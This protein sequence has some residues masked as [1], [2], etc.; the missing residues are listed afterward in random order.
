MT[1]DLRFGDCLNLLPELGPV[2]AVLTDLPYGT[3]QCAW[4]SVIPL[5]LMW[6]SVARVLK[7]SG[8]FVTTASQPFTS[9]LIMSNLD[10]YRYSWVWEKNTGTRF[11]D[12][13]ERPLLFHED[14]C[15]FY[16]EQGTYNPQ[17]Q[18]GPATHSRK[19]Q[20]RTT[21]IY[22]AQRFV[23]SDESGMKYPRTV[24]HFDRPAPS[25]KTAHP[26]EKPLD[27]Y[28]YLVLTYTNP[29]DT[30][31]DLAM[32]SGTTGEACVRLGRNFVGIERDLT[33]FE[34]AEKRI[35]EAEAQ[36]ALF[37]V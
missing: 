36:P 25:T 6:P 12:A 35:R 23:P 4:D 26:S 29:G 19:H 31:L 8:V 17:K 30:V 15:V 9:A 24:L 14:L 33:Y 2:D 32:G 28:Q 21:E 11:M 22:N 1:A 27:L 34:I 37:Q 13:N 5:E 16:Q 7:P 10:W 18:R 20:Q 3:T